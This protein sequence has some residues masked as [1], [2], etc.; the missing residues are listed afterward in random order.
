MSKMQVLTMLKKCCIIIKQ[1][2][3]LWQRLCNACFKHKNL[4]TGGVRLYCDVLDIYGPLY[5]EMV[6][7]QLCLSNF[8]HKETL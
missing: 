1:V 2:A 5:G 7:P 4:M 8:S 3:Q 6:I